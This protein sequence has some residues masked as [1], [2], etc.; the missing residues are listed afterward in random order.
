VQGG[1]SGSGATGVV[2][3]N[4]SI[5]GP[6]AG[7]GISFVHTSE[8][9][10]Q[11]VSIANVATGI[12]M[13]FTGGCDCYNILNGDFVFASGYGLQIATNSYAN[14]NQINGG[15]Y[16][17]TGSSAIYIGGAVNNFFGVDV[18]TSPVAFE[19]ADGGASTVWGP[20]L[21]GNTTDIQFDSGAIGGAVWGGAYAGVV[22][23]S[24]NP[25][26]NVVFTTGAGATDGGVSPTV[27]AANLWRLGGNLYRGTGNSGDLSLVGTL[28]DGAQFNYSPSSTIVYGRT[29]GFPFNVGLLYNAGASYFSYPTVYAL[30]NPSAPT[31]TSVCTPGGSVTCSTS[32]T[33]YVDCYAHNVITN[34]VAQST[35]SSGTTTN[36]APNILSASNYV[37]ITA[38]CGP[39]YTGSAILKNGTSGTVLLAASSASAPNTLPFSDTGQTL[40]S[41]TPPTRN[42]T[43]DMSVV[44]YLGAAQFSI[45]SNVVIPS[46]VTGN[47]G[48][49]AKLQ[50]STGSTTTNDCVKFDAN[51]NTA[52]AGAACGSV[53]SVGGGNG[54]ASSG[55]ATP[56]ITMSRTVRTVTSTDSMSSSDCGEQINSTATSSFTETFTTS[57]IPTGCT[58]K[59][60]NGAAASSGAI[61]TFSIASGSTF[62]GLGKGNTQGASSA[63]LYFLAPQNSL[64]FTYDGT[65]WNIAGPSVQTLYVA[66]GN[67]CLSA[68]ASAS[69]TIGY[70]GSSVSCTQATSATAFTT[71][72]FTFPAY[73]FSANTSVRVSYRYAFTSTGSP[74]LQRTWKLGSTQL[75]QTTA[76]APNSGTNYP[77]GA[78]YS[79]EGTA[80]PSASAVVAMS[81]V[82]RV[83]GL[84]DPLLNSS[85][86]GTFPTNGTL[87]LSETGL[88]SAN[89]AGNWV[90][91]YKVVIN[92]ETF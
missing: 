38:S 87:A 72:A 58:I 22:D 5:Y 75:A 71:G 63:S 3:Q 76:G 11:N 44:G 45:G 56:N 7:T 10:I 35:V 25:G 37:N 27:W 52:D 55:G 21:E 50:L 8:S 12:T 81:A 88:W 23:N 85:W 59:Y 54:V 4:L 17:S 68:P 65:N 46:T 20:Y 6:T 16:N 74:T 51:G 57:S 70:S 92:W 73:F 1:T 84:N 30:P 53:T 61:I 48:N 39:G 13:G 15:R 28:D 82:N 47:Q 83:W 80:A 79:I 26:A 41:Y 9:W 29:G 24:G 89:T 90:D 43:G 77:G 78:E 34:N 18:E 91:Q 42:N 69:Q 64:D 67:S 86:F 33:Y 2:I 49:G 62:T 31:V 36:N 32:L 14:Q 19:F 66:Q 40:T 60:T